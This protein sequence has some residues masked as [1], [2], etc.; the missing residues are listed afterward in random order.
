[1]KKKICFI[2][3]LSMIFLLSVA[4][5]KKEDAVYPEDSDI[6]N[7]SDDKDDVAYPDCFFVPTELDLYGKIN[8]DSPYLATV[9]HNGN[10]ESS[11]LDFAKRTYISV[12]DVG[13]NLNEIEMTKNGFV[14][15][16]AYD[17][18]LYHFG[19]GFD[20]IGVNTIINNSKFRSSTTYY[21]PITDIS[22]D[23]RYS[24]NVYIQGKYHKTGIFEL[25]EDENG[26]YVPDTLNA[27]ELTSDKKA[28]MVILKV[29]SDSDLA[30]FVSAVLKE[31]ETVQ[32]PTLDPE[33]DD[34]DF[35]KLLTSIAILEDSNNLNS[36]YKAYGT[37]Q[38]LSDVT[39]V[40]DILFTKISDLY[41]LNLKSKDV[42]ITVDNVYMSFRTYTDEGKRIEVIFDYFPGA[43]AY[44]DFDTTYYDFSHYLEG[45]LWYQY[46][47]SE[48]NLYDYFSNYNKVYIYKNSELV[49]VAK[50]EGNG[51]PKLYNG[52]LE[53]FAGLSEIFGIKPQ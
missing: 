47:D 31:G 53:L 34:F 29:G 46:T 51:V 7:S 23:P 13:K 14:K 35:N 38:D 25:T 10:I 50:V 15:L 52:N 44:K 40:Q 39:F 2:L 37:K 9:I 27:I 45:D 17:R 16:A 41:G 21:A 36:V 42:A 49:G 43:V 19:L 48:G 26:E 4:C 5:G 33:K 11:D 22:S 18:L 30:Y 12:V 8:L 32:N 28:P 24:E 20:S 3:L 6:P 1:M